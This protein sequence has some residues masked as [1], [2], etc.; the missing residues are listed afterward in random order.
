VREAIAWVFSKICEHHAEVIINPQVME[1]LFP[2]FLEGIASQPRISNQICRALE[3]IAP[4]FSMV[5]EHMPNPFAIYFPQFLS[6]LLNNA[7]RTDSNDKTDLALASYTTLF[8]L[9][10]SA[11]RGCEDIMFSYLVPVLQQLEATLPV[12]GSTSDKK[13][14]EHQDYLSGLLQ[15]LLVKVGERVDEKMGNGIV[16][17]LAKIFTVNHKVTENGLIAYGGLCNGLG[18]KINI[19]DFGIYI[20]W[21]LKSTDDELARLACGTLSDVASAITGN[22]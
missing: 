21:A 12:E 6:A 22:V 3:N 2:K 1:R 14:L 16:T 17:L 8:A 7:Y 13:Q 15:I 20:V 10:E 5:P 4:S 19:K 11:S 18:S 9:C